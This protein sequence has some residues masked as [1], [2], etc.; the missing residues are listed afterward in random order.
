MC[1]Q[2]V[3]ITFRY[4]NFIIAKSSAKQPQFLK[5]VS[6]RCKALAKAGKYSRDKRY[7]LTVPVVTMETMSALL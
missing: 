2:F 6:W 5:P 3:Q 4:R 1:V 7:W